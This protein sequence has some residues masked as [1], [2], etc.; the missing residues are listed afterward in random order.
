MV[1]M[2]MRIVHML[3]QQAAGQRRGGI[4]RVGACLIQRHRIE[5]GEHADVGQDRRIIFRMFISFTAESLLLYT[6]S[7]LQAP[8]QRPQPTQRS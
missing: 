6:A 5:R 1:I 2:E 3:I 4:A 7:K 8:R